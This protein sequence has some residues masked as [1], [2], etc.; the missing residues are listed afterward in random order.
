MAEQDI[1]ASS[2]PTNEVALLNLETSTDDKLIE[3]SDSVITKYSV[4]DKIRSRK[5][6]D[7]DFA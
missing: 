6:Q 4:H 7:C 1:I 3:C 5:C 2:S